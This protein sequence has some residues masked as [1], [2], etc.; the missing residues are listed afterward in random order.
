MNI[1]DKKFWAEFLGNKNIQLE[2]G[3]WYEYIGKY[4]FKRVEFHPDSIKH[5]FPE[6][7]N[8]LTLEQKIEAGWKF[9]A[10]NENQQFVDILLN[11]TPKVLE[12]IKEV[13]KQ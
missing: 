9:F 2:N 4:P 3:T 5:H 11:N 12:A 8:K 10:K 7:W 6:V 1:E 13:V